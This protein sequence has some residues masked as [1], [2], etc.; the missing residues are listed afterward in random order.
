MEIYIG[1]FVY[2]ICS[3]VAVLGAGAALPSPALH[4]SRTASSSQPGRSAWRAGSR[5]SRG[6]R[7]RAAAAGRHASLRLQ[8]RLRRRPSMSE[9]GKLS[10]TDTLRSQ[11]KYSQCSRNRAAIFGPAYSAPVRD[12]PSGLD[13]FICPRTSL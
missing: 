7:L 8:D 1:A 4:R 13:P 10:S 6:E 2:A 3:T 11:E 12:D 5:T 9:A